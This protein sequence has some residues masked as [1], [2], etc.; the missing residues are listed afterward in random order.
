MDRSELA[1]ISCRIGDCRLSL[2]DRQSLGDSPATIDR[3]NLLLRRVLAHLA[4]EPPL[5]G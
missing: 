4:V 5:A 3:C 2:L 1:A